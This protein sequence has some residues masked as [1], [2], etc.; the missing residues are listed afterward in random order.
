MSTEHQQY[1]VCN[2]MDVIR[3]YASR[4]ALDIVRV[5]T[6]EGKS[7]LNIKG[8]GALASMIAEV[9]AG[10]VPFGCILVYDVSRW[11]RFQDADESAHYEFLCRRAGISVHYCA[12]QFENDGSTISTIVKNVKRTMAGEYSRE[13][14]A[15]VFQGACRLIMLGYK[16]GGPAGYGLR[17]MLVDQ[18]GSP[19]EQLS[20]GQHK[21]IQ[22]DRVILVPGPGDEVENVRWVFQAFISGLSEAGIAAALNG[23]GI[24]TDFQ[25]PWSARTVHQVLTNEKYIGNNVYH[26]TSFKLKR[27]RVK[28]SPEEWIRAEGSWAA[29]V[30]PEDF[31]RVQGMIANRT[32]NFTDEEMLASLRTVLDQRGCIS[33]VLIDESDNTPSSSAYRSRFG[34]LMRAYSLIGY[35]PAIDYAFIEENR[36][37]R[38]LHPEVV[39]E[40][41]A[42]LEAYGAE[43]STVTGKDLLRVNGEFLVS[44]VLCRHTVTA[45]GASR[46]TV[47]CEVEHKAD[48]TIAVRLE[49]G[50]RAIRDYYLFPAVDMTFERL[51]MADA[52]RIE[53]D[54]YQFDDLDFFFQMAER[55]RI[56]TL[57]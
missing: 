12:E 33:G 41:V 27:R 1:S 2:Q 48:I 25:R 13:L 31:A 9:V 28:N 47:R 34:S 39:A 14:S 23:R 56:E 57:L 19:K 36:R 35:T 10:P 6:D 52:N 45:R 15:K 24:V 8:R 44:I 42:R 43:V 46:W 20:I 37:I 21:S 5:Y 54:G 38:A 53:L 50:N 17:R 18:N 51:R 11:G 30:S 16:Q 49:C 40:V 4:R 3:A 7:G 22:T 29:I 32:R 55:T 26:R